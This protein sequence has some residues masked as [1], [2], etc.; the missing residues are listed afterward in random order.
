MSEGE[1]DAA[2][3]AVIITLEEPTEQPTEKKAI[4]RTK[5][6]LMHSMSFDIHITDLLR[7]RQEY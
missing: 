4:I 7:T 1:E 3:G 5:K 2:V 6:V